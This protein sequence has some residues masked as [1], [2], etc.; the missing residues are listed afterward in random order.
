MN[1][2]TDAR[3]SPMQIVEAA[4][5]AHGCRI[6]QKG[7]R[8]FEADCP[9][10]DDP[11][12]RSGGYHLIIDEAPNGNVLLYCHHARGCTFAAIMA[13]LGLRASDG[14]TEG[15]SNGR[16]KALTLATLC[17]EKRLDLALARREGFADGSDE[18][19]RPCLVKTYTCADGSQLRRYRRAWKGRGAFGW[20]QGAKPKERGAILGRSH[21][22]EA[23]V[24]GFIISVEGGSDYLSLLQN[25]FP[26][27]GYPGADMVDAETAGRDLARVAKVYLSDERD[28]G[29]AKFLSA[30]RGANG[31]ADRL[32]AI[33]WEP[34]KDPSDAFVNLG[35]PKRFREF[36]E[37][38]RAAAR[39]VAE[40]LAER[41]A[42]V[43]GNTSL[44][45]GGDAGN[46]GSRAYNRSDAGN[47]EI[48]L[49][50]SRDRLRYRHGPEDWLYWDGQRWRPDAGGEAEKLALLAARRRFELSADIPDSKQREA[51]ARWAIG[52]E[53]ARRVR[54][55]LQSAAK[56]IGGFGH[57]PAQFDADPMLLCC[58][59]SIAD[60]G[61]GEWRPPDRS[62]LMTKLAGAEYQPDAR[63]ERWESFL[64]QI[65]AG[66]EELI[67]FV[68]RL[69]GYS[70]TGCVHEHVIAFCHG[71]G[72]NGKSVLLNTLSAALGEY[73]RHGSFDT[74]TE[75]R[76]KRGGIREDLARLLGVRFFTAAEA[77]GGA[78]FD[79]ASIKATTSSDPITAE[80]KYGHVF[81]FL[82][83]HTTWLAAN[84]KP[85]VRDSSLGFWR[86]LLLLPFEVE[87]PEG[88]ADRHLEE[89][90][91]EELPAVLTWVVRGALAWGRD[92]LNPPAKVQIATATYRDREDVVGRFLA[93][94]CT[95]E[96]QAEVG[97]TNLYR[98]Y[99]AWCERAGE[100]ARA[101]AEFGE[102]MARHSLPSER[103]TAGP[104]K[105]RK[106]YRGLAL[107]V[108]GGGEE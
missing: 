98:A 25:G 79:E 32:Y 14:F 75:E 4:L 91:R 41:A 67:G 70:A 5:R 8:R 71:V 23:E 73:A 108:E 61:T 34:F 90:L 49:D 62:L 51:E 55:C 35:D 97:A 76:A 39:P 64:R 60:L 30:F 9:C 48:L 11:Q 1:T 20:P 50:L 95:R 54:D 44:R 43:S 103:R 47:A 100:K 83:T 74:F 19:D 52:S 38:A 26:V 40:V 12:R 102:E 92:G 10:C 46:A 63:G 18:F 28:A 57:F 15:K 101:Q 13:A 42:A 104:D 27:I 21:L 68:Q 53:S 3:N 89:K 87:F 105:G 29:A 66:D 58:C 85:R 37:T 59:N 16:A 72:A 2:P 77:S 45:A 106:R 82:P 99:Q 84:R 33:C 17:S 31:L 65:F 24:A 7:P 107:D 93:E 96:P 69:A 81:Q 22:P 6:R 94:C 78:H 88:R 80:F 86:R 56:S 36:V